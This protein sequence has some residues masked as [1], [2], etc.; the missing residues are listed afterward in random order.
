MKINGEGKIIIDLYNPTEGEEIIEY[1]DWDN[2]TY[3][4]WRFFATVVFQDLGMCGIETAKSAFEK[5]NRKK[6]GIATLDRAITEVKK[7]VSP[8]KF[9]RFIEP[10]L[11][12][13]ENMP[14]NLREWQKVDS[15]YNGISKNVEADLAAFGDNEEMWRERFSAF[16]YDRDKPSEVNTGVYYG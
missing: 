3:K 12:S 10:L 15:L 16:I 1:I 4:T 2:F 14:Y 8:E 6:Q 7:Y 5:I 9:E 13:W 11:Q